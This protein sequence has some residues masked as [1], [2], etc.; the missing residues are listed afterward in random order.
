MRAGAQPHSE[1]ASLVAREALSAGTPVIAYPNGAL[2]EM[3]EHG[4]TGFL[5][6]NVEE[7]AQALSRTA[8][9]DPSVGRRVAIEQYSAER[10]VAQYI[11]LYQH[12]GNVE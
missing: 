3:I 12:L 6:N 10:M 9:L 1:T 5:V 8:E 2:A 4:R 7:M 11:D